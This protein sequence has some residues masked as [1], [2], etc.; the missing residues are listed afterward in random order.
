MPL[1]G[2]LRLRLLLGTLVWIAAAIVIAGWV[3]SGLFRQ[4]VAMQ[5]NAELVTHLDQLTAHLGVNAAGAPFLSGAQSDPRFSK[6]YSGLYW[7]I[8][9][10]SDS[11]EMGKGL[12]RSRS[13]W[14][15]VLRLPPDRQDDGEVHQHRLVGPRDTWLGVVERVVRVDESAEFSGRKF[16]LL[17]A[18]DERQMREPVERFNGL[19]WLALGLLGGA[20]ALVA[21]IQ[22]LIAMAP[23]KRLQEA[24][25]D[26]R[27]GKS[28]R[29][30]GQFPGEVQ[31][32]VEEFNSV[33][34][35]N[36]EG[37]D[38][39]R[40]LAGNL[41]HA[42]K[43]PLSVMANAAQGKQ[44]DLVQVVAEQ[45]E[46]AR[47]QID[48]HLSRSRVAA[49]L[50]LPGV[51]TAV[52]PVLEGLLGVM[53][54]IHAERNLQLIVHPSP[55]ALVFRGEEQDLQELLGNLLDNACKWAR[56]RIEIYLSAF[57][58]KLCVTIDD[59]G[60]GIAE[61]ARERVLTR[62]ARIDER[63][64]GSGLGLAIVGDL[65][66]LYGGEVRLGDSP[67]GGLRV[68]LTLPLVSDLESSLLR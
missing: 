6:P 10:Y 64:S 21:L 5:F 50:S 59:D 41:A 56:Q 67:L 42:L 49:S 57:G 23:L 33:L 55:A 30:A 65:A 27:N 16:R 29:L 68:E 25:A 32:L 18:A 51:R 38:R 58:D 11:P 9:A 52:L 13:L 4:H 53:Q 14:D 43:T 39:A 37:V 3:L 35:Q 63:V 62:G 22:V 7:Q 15:D 36:S 1:R 60:C 17:I 40:K 47:V 31:P 54:R 45:V 2:S 66:Q 19:L 46:V 24:L 26:V 8:E 20:L 61:D 34:Q 44:D 12:L 48:Y 28:P